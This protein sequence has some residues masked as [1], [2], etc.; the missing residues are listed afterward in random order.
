[1]SNLRPDDLVEDRELAAA[2]DDRLAHDGIVDQ[3]AALATT[4]PTPS[5]IALYGPWGSGKS[6]IA[7]MLKSKLDG[8]D[9]VR[10][11][12]FDAF[13][14]ADVPLRR[15][16]ISAVASELGCKQAKY[17][18]DL[19]SGRTKTE[20]K[21]PPTTILK[22]LGVFAL[23][24]LGLA[25]ILA[26]LVAVVALVQ[27]HIGT[28]TDFGLEFRSLSKQVVLAGLLPAALLAALISL[29]S[30]TFSVD[31]SLAKPDS[32]EQFER[33]FK[34]LVLDARAKVLVIFV[35]E[36]DR[37]SA[38]E[39]VATLDTIRTFLGI[40]QC[41][42]I[43]AAD[44]NVLEG[45]LT[46]AAKQESPSD[47]TNPYYS[48]GSA[49]LDK[50]FQYQLSVPPLLAQSVSQYATS[51]VEN[52]K[53]L[54]SEINRDYV[55]S[56]LIPT[57]VTS[58]RR[59]K[60]LLNTFA[61]TFR[62][63]QER[64]N[65]GLLA[66]DPCATAPA[67]ARFVCLRVEFPLFARHL[68]VDANLPA[69][70]LQ[71]MQNR[72]AELP[73]GTSDRAIE[74][75]ES[76]AHGCA[77]PSTILVED[78]P[79]GDGCSEDRATQ[80]GK[81]HNKQLLNYLSRTRQVRG[82]SRDLIYMQ[83]TGTVF[84]LDGELALAVERAAEDVDTETLR[85]RV[86][87]LEETQ[88]EGVLQVLTNLIRT[89]TGVI[90]PNAARSF[91][92]LTR[93]QP[94]L[95][96]DSVADT[97]AE[98]ICVLEDESDDILDEDTV[99]GAWALTKV[100]SE[101]SAS[102]LRQRIIAASTSRD[103]TPPDFLF[104][105]AALAIS[106]APTVVP[107]YLSTRLVSPDGPTT[108]TRLF[109]LSDGDLAKVISATHALISTL[110]SEAERAHV[111]WKTARE[112][113]MATGAST[114]GTRRNTVASTATEDLEPEP[115]APSVVL[116][117]LAD[118]A[119]PREEPIQHLV[120][121]L[122]L[123]VDTQVARS[124][125]LRLLGNT[126]PVT[127]PD[128]ATGILRAARR[129]VL[130]E[131]TKWLNCIVPANV[132]AAHAEPL[133]QLVAKAWESKSDLDITGA[134]L[135]V[136]APLIAN[137]PEGHAPSLTADVLELV[138]RYVAS[139]NEASER[140]ETLKRARLFAE[141][142]VLD[143]DQIL[144]AVAHSLQDTLAE[145]LAQVDAEDALYRYLAENGSEAVQASVDELED[146]E[147]EGLL[148]EASGSP[149][150]DDLG[151]VAI[152]LD[153][154]I[155]A[156]A[157]RV[158]SNVLPTAEAMAEVTDKYAH[159]AIH[160]TALWLELI[161]PSPEDFATVYD[162]LRR[163]GAHSA[164]LVHAARAVQHRWTA[165]QHRDLLDK[166]LAAADTDVP[167]DAVLEVLGVA[168]ADESQVAD[169]LVNRFTDA[170]N[171]TQRQRVVTLWGK[172]NVQGDSIRRR[173][174]ETIIYGLLDLKSEGGNVGAA[175]LALNALGSVGKPLP[176]RIKGA[177]GE[178]VKS[179]VTGTSS[180]EDKALVVLPALGYPIARKN[181]GKSRRV[182]YD[183]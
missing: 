30:K 169:L 54:W 112:A 86:A 121:R 6:G 26:T 25:V 93:A 40:E 61:L 7:N 116:D 20:I 168:E 158:H 183:R 140:R 105:D 75:A 36:L 129:R 149:W 79:D 166:Y 123:D 182:R 58:P 65:A 138:A 38:G 106:A 11:V 85:R 60:H 68:E 33:I 34:N 126:E 101:A 113:A 173:L 177:L 107:G 143:Y 162:P 44:Q 51:L 2:E 48:T 22:L 111:E 161:R 21:V 90:G 73:A 144:S 87:G 83:S 47:D 128:L 63:A 141:A 146:S 147:L 172:A 46:R 4:V 118:A 178:R 174:F 12:R 32:D 98:A 71:I 95:P 100:G 136:L 39:V 151:H 96:V 5:N 57:H 15:N 64:H 102:A 1:M 52:R 145:S 31:R 16:F 133:G 127:D 91:L 78:D 27:S 45:A 92:L 28:K 155:A 135:D 43:V 76:Y 24:L 88:L 55:L 165:E 84:G 72:D 179:A 82:P 125:A 154:A 167:D 176:S 124:A 159:S 114:A 119:T 171:N 150:L 99:T 181:L 142:R 14:Y 29:A 109:D 42:F 160:V 152:P 120:L 104:E 180:L 13:K 156:G 103:F 53:G 62:L 70:V 50:V 17:H 164:E 175:E 170:T 10:F 18:G 89:G 56:V 41:V 157:T 139:T 74:L 37:C 163:T 35:D 148:A 115:F 132:T 134:A 110:A 3:L 130:G 66:E 153:L 122:L 69:L 19:Y 23:L 80:I 81:A 9:G 59:V 94:D 97:V 49:Y 77:A 137:L 131:W 8:R 67:I 108:V 117:A